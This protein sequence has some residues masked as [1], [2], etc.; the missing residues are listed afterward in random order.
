MDDLGTLGERAGVRPT[1]AVPMPA[2]NLVLVFSA[3][4]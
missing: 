1:R 4:G 2:K 3:A